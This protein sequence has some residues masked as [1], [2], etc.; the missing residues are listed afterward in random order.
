MSLSR[1]QRH[2]TP[3]WALSE[4]MAHVELL[5]SLPFN[6]Q[7]KGTARPG[8]G[9]SQ[10]IPCNVELEPHPACLGL[11]FPPALTACPPPRRGWLPKAESGTLRDQWGQRRGRPSMEPDH[12]P[13]CQLRGLGPTWSR[14]T[15]ST[16]GGLQPVLR[17]GCVL[18]RDSRK[19]SRRC[20]QES[21]HR[22]LF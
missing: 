14:S 2:P 19:L 7:S 16:L 11:G 22:G 20:Q 21:W 10:E 5:L 17:L 4:Q 3:L 18:N 15:T 6:H 13:I 8:G 9:W 1:E 12:G